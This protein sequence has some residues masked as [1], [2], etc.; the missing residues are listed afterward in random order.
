MLELR[1]RAGFAALSVAP[2]VLLAGAVTT[3]PFTGGATAARTAIVLAA[4]AAVAAERDALDAVRLAAPL[5]VRD[6]GVTVAAT[7]LG[8]VATYALSV[9]A[10]LGPVL[11]SAGVGLVAGLA[12][13]SI[14]VAVY[15]GSFV[16]MASPALFPTSVGVATG[17][18]AAG[19]G[20]VT[21]DG[22]FDGVGGKLGTLAFAGCLAAA[23]ATTATFHSA[24]TLPT[25]VLLVTAPVAAVAA[26]VAFYLHAE[27]GH[28]T[29]VA[30][31]LVGVLAVALRPAFSLATDA[32]LAAVAFCASF[33]GMSA[34]RRL[35]DGRV[36]ALAGALAA[37]IYLLTSRVF[38]GAGGKLGTTA[39]VACTAVVGVVEVRDRLR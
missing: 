4:G 35:H 28:S 21:A 9:H 34:P 7:V 14:A 18:F 29:V 3:Q 20:L 26:V 39:F 1:R 24:T 13:P 31:A 23:A 19:I 33:V 32:P 37:V 8:S 2:A 25:S 30:S 11:A 17:G 22:V 16:G 5:H 27:R 10:G 6:A 15:C 36:V 12:A 38:G